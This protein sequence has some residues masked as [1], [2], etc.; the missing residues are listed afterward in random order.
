[1]Y[2]VAKPIENVVAGKI[3][4]WSGEL[5]FGTQYKLPKS[6]GDLVE[7]SHL[8]RWMNKQDLQNALDA[9]GAP[10]DSYCLGGEKDEALCL[11]ENYG[12]W[13]VY[14]SER[15]QRTEQQAFDSEAAACAAFLMRLRKMFRI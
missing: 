8:R 2:E 1:M 13:Y 6:V 12:H 4:P 3:A 11:A 14:Y 7:S 10:R 15:G 9:V 5:G